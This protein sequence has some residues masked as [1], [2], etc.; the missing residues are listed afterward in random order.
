M[1]DNSSVTLEN[2]IK[3]DVMDKIK[4]DNCS[5]I[6]LINPLDKKD[7]CI[8]KEIKG[9]DDNYLVGLDS[10]DEFK[11]ALELFISKNKEDFK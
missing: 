10:D 1:I 3:Y 4:N 9:E 5:Y 7:I 2:G 6:Y 8:R 11:K